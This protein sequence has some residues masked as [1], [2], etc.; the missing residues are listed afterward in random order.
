MNVFL[1]LFV[2]APLFFSFL[3]QYFGEYSWKIKYYQHSMQQES[4][5]EGEMKIC[6]IC[7][8]ESLPLFKVCDCLGSLAYVHEGCIKRWIRCLVGERNAKREPECELCGAALSVT[9]T[10]KLDRISYLLLLSQLMGLSRMHKLLSLLLL[11]ILIV[12]FLVDIELLAKIILFLVDGEWK[13]SIYMTGI[14]IFVIIVVKVLLPLYFVK[15][16]MKI[17]RK[18]RKIVK[19]SRLVVL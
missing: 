6:R 13:Q 17:L 5:Y 11:I 3:M 1:I 9:L 19:R 15:S 16:C 12:T 7:H 10:P 14:E 2:H 18:L 8:D 4:T